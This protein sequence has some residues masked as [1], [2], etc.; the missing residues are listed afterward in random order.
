MAATRW[1]NVA[2]ALVRA[3]VETHLDT[4]TPRKLKASCQKCELYKSPAQKL[5][6]KSLSGTF[7][8]RPPE[9]CE[10]RSRRAASATATPSQK[11]VL[12]PGIAYPRR[13][14]PRGGRRHRRSCVGV[15]RWKAGQRVAVG[16]H[17][18]TAATAMPAAAAAFSP[19][20]ASPPSPRASTSDGGYAEYM[21]ARAEAYSLVPDE[22]SPVEA[23]P[24]V[25][26]GVTT[27]NCLRNAGARARRLVGVVGLGGLG[28]LGV[29][30]AA[31][32]RMYTPSPSPDIV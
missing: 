29:Q 23:A 28:H 21:I 3:H 25:C 7:P 18:E 16:W 9:Q 31:K 24:L 2:H 14:R 13:A 6:L 4:L 11:M 30:Y 32:G 1:L 22:L 17:G 19:A 10:S 27:Y 5:R 12:F 20:R 15:P 26:A 8:S